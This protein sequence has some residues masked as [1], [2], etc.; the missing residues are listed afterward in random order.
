MTDDFFGTLLIYR[1]VNHIM[2]KNM[3]I[4]WHLVIEVWQDIYENVFNTE[5]SF[6]EKLET[7]HEVEDGNTRWQEV[8]IQFPS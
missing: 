7:V 8:E 4:L 5:D 1:V 6:A 2:V 3:W